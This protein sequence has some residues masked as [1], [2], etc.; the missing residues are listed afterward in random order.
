VELGAEGF[1]SSDHCDKIG[2]RPMPVEECDSYDR[3][4]WNTDAILQGT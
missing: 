3:G 1:Q 2:M 4:A